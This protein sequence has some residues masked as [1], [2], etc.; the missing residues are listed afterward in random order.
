MEKGRAVLSKV[1]L[2][3]S[4]VGDVLFP[5]LSPEVEDQR[6]RLIVGP[7]WMTNPRGKPYEVSLV[8]FLFSGF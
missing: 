7:K 8:F 5:A 2:R 4:R 6:E 3:G 1:T